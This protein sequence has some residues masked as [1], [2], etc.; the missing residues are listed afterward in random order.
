MDELLGLPGRTLLGGFCTGWLGGL[1]LCFRA[2]SQGV[3]GGWLEAA[4]R[5]LISSRRAYCRMQGVDQY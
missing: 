3:P 2:Q 5:S 1:A 4:Q